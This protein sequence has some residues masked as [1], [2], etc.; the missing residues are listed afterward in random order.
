MER[1]TNAISSLVEGSE[2]GGKPRFSPLLEDVPWL[3]AAGRPDSGREA[4]QVGSGRD[5]GNTL[6]FA[7]QPIADLRHTGPAKWWE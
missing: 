7:P 4:H 1:I 6:H 5:Q 3:E 2:F